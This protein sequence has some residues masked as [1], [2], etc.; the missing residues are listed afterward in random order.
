MP[1]RSILNY[2]SSSLPIGYTGSAGPV[3]G[4]NTTVAFND[5]GSANGTTGFTFTKSS[6]NVFV[7]NTITAAAAV[8][9]NNGFFYN[10]S[11]LT[12]N[13]SYTVPTGL[14]GMC[15]GPLNIVS[16]ATFTVPTGQRILVF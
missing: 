11:N 10:S 7:G 1:T 12:I 16:G 5:S 6:N 2:I 8:T 13:T 15:I 3:A 4:S 9:A 14:S